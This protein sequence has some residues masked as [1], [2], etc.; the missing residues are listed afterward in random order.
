VSGKSG[1]KLVVQD[2]SGKMTAVNLEVDRNNA[3]ATA[4]PQSS[5]SG[6][7]FNWLLLAI[8]GVIVVAGVGVVAS[9]RSKTA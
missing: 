7:S 8:I 3:T 4:S 5:D 6:S 2:P 9:R 1:V